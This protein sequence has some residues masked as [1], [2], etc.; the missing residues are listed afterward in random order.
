MNQLSD[1]T[2][3]GKILRW[4]AGLAAP[5]PLI[6]IELTD[7][8]IICGSLDFDSVTGPEIDDFLEV[9]GS[10]YLPGIATPSKQLNALWP[11]PLIT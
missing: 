6:V 3:G 4:L 1:V 5:I 11:Y 10:V 2:A 9:H 8:R 7:E